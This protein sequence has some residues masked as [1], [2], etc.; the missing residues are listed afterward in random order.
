MKRLYLLFLVI[1]L[2]ACDESDPALQ[3]YVEGDLLFIAAPVAGNLDQLAVNE[4]DDVS[5]SQLLFA[6]N[7]EPE[8]SALLNVQA[9]VDIA[10]AELADLQ[11]GSRPEE[12]AVIE[13]RYAQAKAAAE[14]SAQQL[15]RVRQ[16]VEKKLEGQEALDEITTKHELNR[17]QLEEVK[18]QLD[19]ARLAARTDRVKAAQARVSAAEAQVQQVQWQVNEK[20]QHAPAAGKIQDVLYRVGEFIP[21]GQPVVT[22]L[23]PQQI[24][25]R[26]FV[27]QATLP[28]LKTGQQVSILCDGCAAPISAAIDFISQQA[29]Y[30]PPFIYSKENRDKFVYLVEAKPTA[31]LTGQLRP[32]Q[33]VD[34]SL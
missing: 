27:S 10:K 11:K 9:Q 14:L 26:F 8:A 24:K 32:G 1:S 31:N 2:S 7:P 15:R 18:A 34:V 25:I 12:L 5:K 23:P 30:T 17:K 6:L 21:A 19:S 22:L 16:L 4:G 3:G 29:E 13:A 28:T 20:I 33:P